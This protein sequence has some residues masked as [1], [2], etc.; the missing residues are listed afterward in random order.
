MGGRSRRVVEG[1]LICSLSEGGRGKDSPPALPERR[2]QMSAI[3][4]RVR[5]GVTGFS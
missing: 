4:A 1:A 5:Q 3:K 2:V